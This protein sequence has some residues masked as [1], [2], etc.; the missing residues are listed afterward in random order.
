[1]VLFRRRGEGEHPVMGLNNGPRHD[2]SVL[3]S[4]SPQCRQGARSDWR[5]LGAP[6][7][8]PRTHTHHRARVGTLARNPERAGRRPRSGGKRRLLLRRL[9]AFVGG[10]LSREI[11]RIL[12]PALE[13]VHGPS[14]ARPRTAKSPRSCEPP[15]SRAPRLVLEGYA[16]ATASPR[17]PPAARSR[18]S[19]PSSGTRRSRRQRSTPP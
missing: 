10:R 17:S 12:A 11:D 6:S 15:A 3:G 9:R 16:T 18:P 14:P 5:K 4:G 2:E 8:G 1:M 7:L 19:P 13:R